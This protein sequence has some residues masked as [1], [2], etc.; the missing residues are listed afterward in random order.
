MKSSSISTNGEALSQFLMFWYFFSRELAPTEMIAA[1][2]TTWSQQ[3]RSK[4]SNRV[5]FIFLLFIFGLFVNTRMID[6]NGDRNPECHFF[7][8]TVPNPFFV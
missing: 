7:F 3:M 1:T 5:S 4:W 8:F 2:L 6:L